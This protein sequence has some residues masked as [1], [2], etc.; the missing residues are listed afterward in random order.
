MPPNVST[1]F[2]TAETSGGVVDQDVDAA[3]GLDG[4]VDRRRAGIARARRSRTPSAGL[5]RQAAGNLR[6]EDPTVTHRKRPHVRPR[7]KPRPAAQAPRRLLPLGALAAGFGLM[8]AQALAQVPPPSAETAAPAPP[9]A[10]SAPEGSRQT[11]MP[12]ITVTAK[13]DSDATSA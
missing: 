2:L 6:H 9:S 11:T 12:T 7:S 10:A 3:D 4:V 13:P 8:Q 1:V 5:P